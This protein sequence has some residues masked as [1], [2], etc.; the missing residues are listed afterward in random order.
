[1]KSLCTLD[2]NT[3]LN[4]ISGLPII[5]NRTHCWDDGLRH[6]SR[7]RVIHDSREEIE[8]S[9]YTAVLL[10]WCVFL[11]VAK[12]H[13]AVGMELFFVLIVVKTGVEQGKFT[14]FR[15]PFVPT[16]LSIVWYT[17][18]LAWMVVC[19]CEEYSDAVYSM[20]CKA[21]QYCKDCFLY[22]T[23]TQSLFYLNHVLSNH[24][25]PSAPSSF[26]NPLGHPHT[27]QNSSCSRP[28]VDFAGLR[29]IST[30]GCACTLASIRCTS[31]KG[32]IKLQKVSL[33]EAD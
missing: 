33:Y 8:D 32:T 11:F 24:I 19:C 27:K 12:C 15:L 28:S 13:T 18:L 29:V 31:V 20:L 25:L 4:L 21:Y 10:L 7:K 17:L 14:W 26:N 5:C 6:Y 22:H 2:I 9:R 3:L 23:P 30:G 1:M 16:V